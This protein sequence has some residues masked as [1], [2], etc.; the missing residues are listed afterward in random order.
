MPGLPAYLFS[1][2][3]SPAAMRTRAAAKAANQAV[4]T[5]DEQA[6]PAQDTQPTSPVGNKT[7][8]D[9]KPTATARGKKTAP[10]KEEKTRA[11]D[12]KEASS[13]KGKRAASA[14]SNATSNAT[15]S[16][17]SK[18]NATPGPSKALPRGKTTASKQTKAA[19]KPNKPPPSSPPDLIDLVAEF[20]DL[21]GLDAARDALIEQHGQ[22]ADLSIDHRSLKEIYNAWLALKTPLAAEP[23][24]KRKAYTE[25]SSDEDS[26]SSSIDEPPLLKILKMKRE[27]KEEPRKDWGAIVYGSKVK[28]EPADDSSLYSSL[29]SGSDSDSDSDSD[30]DSDSESNLH[31]SAPSIIPDAGNSTNRHCSSESDSSSGSDSSSSDESLDS[32]PS[33]QSWPACTALASIMREAP[34]RPSVKSIK[35][36]SP[37]L[38]NLQ[39][40]YGVNH[41]PP[42]N[43]QRFSRI[44]RDLQVDARFASNQYV[45]M[46]Y[47]RRAHQDLSVTRGKG[48]TKEKNKKKRGSFR[49]GVIDIDDK[50]GVYFDD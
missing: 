48:F 42:I 35:L 38:D 22:V 19:P 30:L 9:K 4:P 43:N 2:N 46:D 15:S 17:S 5:G 25:S 23:T 13:T 27:F 32:E 7:A 37:A 1:N 3:K 18:K 21:E 41:R 31:H 8:K 33:R 34:A 47:S 16:A 6:A 24:R 20:L 29:G 26:M 50:K 36:E 14:R 12:K 11:T 39:P 44:P 49:G 45:E 40:I 10:A 28:I